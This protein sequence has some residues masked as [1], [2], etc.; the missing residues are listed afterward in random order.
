MARP[1]TVYLCQQCAHEAAKWLG[2]CPACGAWNTL[3]ETARVDSPSPARLLGARP[4]AVA[5]RSER[6]G[7]L[8]QGTK[9]QVLAVVLLFR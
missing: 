1:K 9:M 8:W 7:R 5:G 6:P 3:V 4:G 2:Q